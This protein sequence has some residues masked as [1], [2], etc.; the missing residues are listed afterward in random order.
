MLGVREECQRKKES[1]P[2][3]LAPQVTNRGAPVCIHH[4]THRVTMGVAASLPALGLP[5][6]LLIAQPSE[7]R[8]G[9]SLALTRC[10]HPA[11]PSGPAPPHLPCGLQL[12]PPPG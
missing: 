11:I 12:L 10:L 5:D 1:Q 9:S 6:I 8:E 4:K 7:G 2:L 3:S